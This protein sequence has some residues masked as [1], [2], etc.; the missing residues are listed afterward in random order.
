ME[1][2]ARG[3][4]W[5]EKGAGGLV[6]PLMPPATVD[7][8]GDPCW[9]VMGQGGERAE[10]TGGLGMPAH[11]QAPA[12]PPQLTSLLQGRLRCS[13]CSLVSD[14]LREHVSP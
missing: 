10:V 13:S 1:G 9:Q 8:G 3:S 7:I 5:C 6:M 4:S 12:L 2:A 14:L 11:L